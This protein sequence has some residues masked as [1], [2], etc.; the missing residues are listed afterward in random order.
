MEIDITDFVQKEEPA[1]FSAS[2]AE[3]G[4]DAGRITWRN[5][6]VEGER[7]PLLTTPEAIEALRDWARSSGGWD[8]EE[9]AAWSDVECNALFVQIISGDLRELESLCMGADGEIDWDKA[10]ELSERGTINGCMYPCDVAGHPQ[11][12]RIFYYLGD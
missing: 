10:H 8:D 2:V 12:G 6:V 5:A 9:I 1:N 3:L 11:H 4:T 7:A